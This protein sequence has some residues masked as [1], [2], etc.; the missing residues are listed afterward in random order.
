MPTESWIN[1]NGHLGHIELVRPVFRVKYFY[2]LIRILHCVCFRCSRLLVSP[3]DPRVKDI[4]SKRVI[5]SNERLLLLYD[6]CINI[7]ICDGG[8][9]NLERNS[10]EEGSSDSWAPYSSHQGCGAY[11]PR[12]WRSGFDLMVKWKVPNS[13]EE[14]GKQTLTAERVRKVMMYVPDEDYTAM[15]FDLG[16]IHPLWLIITVLPV[17]PINGVTAINFFE[18][19]RDYD[20]VI[21]EVCS[22]INLN[23][24]IIRN[25]KPEF[26]NNE[27]SDLILAQIVKSIEFHVASMF[28]D[29]P[30]TD[31]LGTLSCSR[32]LVT[33]LCEPSN[34]SSFVRTYYTRSTTLSVGSSKSS[35]YDLPEVSY[36]P[37]SP[38]VPGSSSSGPQSPR[39]MDLRGS[40]SIDNINNNNIAPSPSYSPSSPS[41]SPMSSAYSP[42]TFPSCSPTSSSCSPVTSA[43]RS[44]VTPSSRS[45]V[46][47]RSSSPIPDDDL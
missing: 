25:E 44:P 39:S 12:I 42:S 9:N 33:T 3:N 22:I 18:F 17:P 15:G 1:C 19:N 4:F 21:K 6:L 11:Q 31:R 47:S 36:S 20:N 45:P 35:M 23:N 28:Q 43:S 27:D 38:I 2:W 37:L 14:E 5:D 24:E 32:N 34:S 46:T 13:P 26:R 29:L 41:Y 8:E 7:D 16:R 10:L 30:N 40:Y